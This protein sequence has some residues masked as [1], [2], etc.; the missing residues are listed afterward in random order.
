[1]K[2]SDLLVARRLADGWSNRSLGLPEQA[3][4][5][6]KKQ[7]TG[8]YFLIESPANALKKNPYSSRDH[9]SSSGHLICRAF[10][11]VYVR[12]S[13]ATAEDKQHGY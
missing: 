13:R 3:R 11:H 6:K 2:S 12:T 1:M 7:R 5:H 4:H 9:S 10:S 8:G